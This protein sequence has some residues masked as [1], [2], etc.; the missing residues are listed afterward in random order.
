MALVPNSFRGILVRRGGEVKQVGFWM[1]VS[2]AGGVMAE[3][4]AKAANVIDTL[5]WE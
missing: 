1:G 3:V 2:L 4:A 5:P